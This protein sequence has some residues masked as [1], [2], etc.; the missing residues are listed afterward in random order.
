MKVQSWI[1]TVRYYAQDI[2]M[3]RCA[4]VGPARASTAEAALHLAEVPEASRA[5]IRGCSLVRNFIDGRLDPDKGGYYGH[6]GGATEASWAICI[7]SV[8]E[9]LA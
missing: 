6:S 9:V 2:Q 5:E 3:R 8:Q 1:F 7:G 4:I